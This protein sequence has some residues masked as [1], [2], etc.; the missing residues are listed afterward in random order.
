[1]PPTCRKTDT[2]THN[3]VHVSNVI[4]NVIVEGQP[5]SVIG[6]V[7]TPDALC[8]P[9][10]A[11]HCAPVVVAGSSNVIAGGKP[12]TRIGDANDCGAVNATGA[13][14]VITGG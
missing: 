14:T 9:V 10:G 6:T 8:D 5:C 2:N 11:P 7:L 13:S 4:G 3:G 1:M 12:V